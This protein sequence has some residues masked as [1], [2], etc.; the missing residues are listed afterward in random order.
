MKQV[1]LTVEDWDKLSELSKKA[2]LHLLRVFGNKQGLDVLVESIPFPIHWKAEILGNSFEW[3][4]SE[5]GS[6]TLRLGEHARYTRN[7]PPIFYVS[8]G[9]FEGNQFCWLD[10][11]G[12]IVPFFEKEGEELVLE[13]VRL[14]LQWEEGDL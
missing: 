14:Y 2:V 10:P 1:P 5:M 13:K 12:N 6:V 11:E 4:V 7:P 8:L 9:K 3:I